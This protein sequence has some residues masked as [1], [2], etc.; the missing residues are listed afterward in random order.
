MPF[1][2]QQLLV[3]NR[4]THF[5]ALTQTL[6]AFAGILVVRTLSLINGEDGV[7]YLLRRRFNL[8]MLELILASD[9]VLTG[10]P[11]GTQPPHISPV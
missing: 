11:P 2:G 6:D 7:A 5:V 8:P 3:Q 4:F 9:S 10:T 1:V